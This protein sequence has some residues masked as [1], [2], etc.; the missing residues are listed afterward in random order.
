MYRID[1]IC[2]RIYFDSI[3]VDNAVNKYKESSENL[4]EKIFINLFKDFKSK[5]TQLKIN[6]LVNRPEAVEELKIMFALIDKHL[7]S[8]RE[9]QEKGIA[10]HLMEVLLNNISHSEQLWKKIISM[11]DQRDTETL[12]KFLKR[13]SVMKSMSAVIENFLNSLCQVGDEFFVDT[14]EHDV[15][16]RQLK[17]FN[18][19]DPSHMIIVIHHL[20]NLPT[21]AAFFN[22]QIFSSFQLSP[23][24]I[25][26]LKQSLRTLSL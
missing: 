18:N 15:E 13:R 25:T 6:K 2:D 4:R 1:A 16:D 19:L 17:L 22:H 11:I 26:F 7:S 21:T 8:E 10:T 20:L 9:K 23:S 24:F 5:E 12:D 3:E 14:G